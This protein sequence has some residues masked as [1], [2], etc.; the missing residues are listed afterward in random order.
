VLQNARIEGVRADVLPRVELEMV[1]A[2]GEWEWWDEREV[3]MERLLRKWKA[4]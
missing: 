3:V 1:C 2:S 4:H